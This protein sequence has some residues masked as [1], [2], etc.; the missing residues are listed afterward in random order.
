MRRDGTLTRRVHG[1][2]TPM[3]KGLVPVSRLTLAVGHRAGFAQIND[4]T[5][6]SV[7]AVMRF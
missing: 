7:G 1:P 5:R 6:A 3:V 2:L 4:Q